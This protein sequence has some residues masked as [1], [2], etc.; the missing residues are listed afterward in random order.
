MR[1]FVSAD[2]DGMYYIYEL[3]LDALRVCGLNL[4][5]LDEVARIVVYMG[6]V[7]C[8]VLVD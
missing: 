5:M 8:D 1:R 2:R 7:L 6:W 3:V 4:V